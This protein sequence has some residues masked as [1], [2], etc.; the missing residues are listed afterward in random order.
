M[1]AQC[2][3]AQQVL[4]IYM[5][6]DNISQVISRFLFV[7]T[8]SRIM[9]LMAIDLFCINKNVETLVFFRS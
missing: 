1:V 5:D 3:R 2:L 9:K 6:K 8:A 4:L 7:T